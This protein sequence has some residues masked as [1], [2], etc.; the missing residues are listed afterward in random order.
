MSTA[1]AIWT[2]DFTKKAAGMLQ[3]YV[4]RVNSTREALHEHVNEIIKARSDFGATSA[5]AQLKRDLMLAEIG[6][7]IPLENAVRRFIQRV[8]Q[9][10][11]HE[12]VQDSN[13][14]ELELRIAD[15]EQSLQGLSLQS[16]AISDWAHRE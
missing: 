11:E 6:S 5:L 14:W 12:V 15:L 16:D 4:G 3:E 1:E 7:C 9:H 13:R 10:L 2:D 8:S